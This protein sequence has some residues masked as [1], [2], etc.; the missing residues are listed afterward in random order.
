MFPIL[1]QLLLKKKKKKKKAKTQYAMG[2]TASEVPVREVSTCIGFCKILSQ[3][4]LPFNFFLQ[5]KTF[6]GHIFKQTKNTTITQRK[7]TASTFLFTGR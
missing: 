2:N 1:E 4:D 7:M 5:Q 3:Q 6:F